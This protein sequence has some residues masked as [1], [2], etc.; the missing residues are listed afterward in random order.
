MK[1]YKTRNDRRRYEHTTGGGRLTENR[2]RLRARIEDFR[3][4]GFSGWLDVCCSAVQPSESSESNRAVRWLLQQN[5]R[6][7]PT[8]LHNVERAH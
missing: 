6:G 1:L 7:Q 5:I 4:L 3:I 2:Q 8:A